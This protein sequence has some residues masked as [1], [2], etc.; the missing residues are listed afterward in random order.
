MKNLNQE[1]KKMRR[2]TTIT[3]NETSFSQ[4]TS[5]RQTRSQSKLDS[6]TLNLILDESLKYE[7]IPQEPKK[8]KIFS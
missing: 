7:I 1:K 3:N 6:D 5:R 4:L 8:E 2:T